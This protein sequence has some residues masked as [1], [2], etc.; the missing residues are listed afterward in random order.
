MAE[1]VR[2]RLTYEEEEE[3]EGM[4]DLFPND[5]EYFEPEQEKNEND[6][7]GNEIMVLKDCLSQCVTG[8]VGVFLEEVKVENGEPVSSVVVSHRM[9][10]RPKC[11]VRITPEYCYLHL[12][13]EYEN[14]NEAIMLNGMF[15]QYTKKCTEFFTKYKEGMVLST[16]TLAFNIIKE[17]KEKGIAYRMSFVNPIF[18]ARDGATLK[19]AFKKDAMNYGI[20]EVDFKQIEREV[21]YEEKAREEELE[22]AEKRKQMERRLAGLPEEDDEA[23]GDEEENEDVTYDNDDEETGTYD[24]EEDDE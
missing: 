9:T 20:E 10:E 11:Y 6:Y 18:S 3:M 16:Y 2:K 7:L 1:E 15:D 21:D 14:D 22:K 12:E 23:E 4:E 8:K 13:F 17:D 24:E 5:D 19:L